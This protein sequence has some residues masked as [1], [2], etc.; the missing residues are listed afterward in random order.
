MKTPSIEEVKDYFKDA[1]EV[2]SIYG[3]VGIFGG[4]IHYEA[5]AYFSSK[6]SD[7]GHLALWREE[8]GYATILTR[9]ENEYKITK[10][11][12]LKLHN[13]EG[14][15]YVQEWFPEC[16]KKELIVGRWYKAMTSLFCYQENDNSYGFTDGV[17]SNCK[18]VVDGNYVLE[19]EWI[20]IEETPKEVEEAFTKHF[21]G[22]GFKNGTLINAVNSQKV[23]KIDLG[24]KTEF[25]AD[26][27]E[28]W[29]G[30]YLLFK[31]G[32][33]AQILPTKKKMTI[34]EIEEK[35]GHGVEVVMEFNIKGTI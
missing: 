17:W 27:N 2:K 14:S 10:E 35:L 28:F 5:N 24:F 30:G 15:K 21:D 29:R 20:P 25:K 4:D 22:L 31:D 3:T 6:K 34:S 32:K 7:V 9:K 16:F 8:Y 33:F 13:H 12:I 26:Y 1:L 23:G 19:K 11:Q 18:W